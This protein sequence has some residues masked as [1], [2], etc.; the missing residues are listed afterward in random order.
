M[1]PRGAVQLRSIM[2]KAGP[3]NYKSYSWRQPLETHFRKATCEEA[4]CKAFTA[5]WVTTV[6]TATELGQRQ[7]HFITHDKSR[8]HREER[9][10]GLVSFTFEPGQQ[11]FAGSPKHEHRKPI[12]Y[13]PITLVTGG[14]FRGNPRRTQPVVMRPQDFVDDFANHLDRLAKAQR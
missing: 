3:E 13:D 1:N 9:I 6:D 14:D 7:Y 4:R 12:G 10:G 2:P 5:G 11:F 8:R